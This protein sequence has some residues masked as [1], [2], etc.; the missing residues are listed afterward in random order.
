MHNNESKVLP[1]WFEK[2]RLS[3]HIASK[4]ELI[5]AYCF[6]SA[7][8]VNNEREADS[9]G[10]VL[11]GVGSSKMCGLAFIRFVAGRRGES[12][13]RRNDFVGWNALSEDF[14]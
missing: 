8:G 4:M 13:V 11:T 6:I 3:F 1:N 5:K 2:Y 14:S 10:L 9:S 12:G 7:Q